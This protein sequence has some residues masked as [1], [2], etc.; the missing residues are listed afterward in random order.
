MRVWDVSKGTELA[1]VQCHQYGV[2]CAAFDSSGDYVVSVGCQQDMAV[3]VWEWRVRMNESKYRVAISAIN[4]IY[5]NS[6][7][8]HANSSLFLLK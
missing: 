1:E 6:C 2:T 3:S 4:G 8:Q 5:V 7:M